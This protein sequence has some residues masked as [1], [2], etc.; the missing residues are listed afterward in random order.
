MV[1]RFSRRSA[2]LASTALLAVAA[3]PCAGAKELRITIPRSSKLTVVQRLNREGVEAARKHEPERAQAYFYKAYLYDPGDPF[4]LNNLGYAAEIQGDAE[5]AQKFYGLA[6]KQD[7]D[8]VID[9]SSLNQ[10]RGKP[11]LYALQD[12]QDAS[13]RLN[14]INVE[15]IELLIQD[16]GF[17]AARL[18]DRALALDPRNP[19]TLNNLGVAEEL[20]GDLEGAAMHYGAAAETH[21][22]EA[23]VVSPKRVWRGKAISEMASNSLE[24][25]QA[26]LEKEGPA[27]ARAVMLALRGVTAANGNDW[28]QAK[29]DF[30]EAYSLDPASAF[31]LNN[32]GYV[33]EKE[34]DLETAQFFYGKARRAG[35]AAARVGVATQTAAQ[36]RPMTVVADDS[37]TKVDT[38]LDRFRD[39]QRLQ[40]E[41]PELVPRGA[42]ASPTPPEPT[43]P[44]NPQP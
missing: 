33:A 9:L 38:E 41:P 32:R 26:E 23:I 28:T 17:E 43:A 13:M 24:R 12:L 27:K 44:A 7:C 5:R 8:A 37:H 3:W 35:D 29:Q 16:R 31:S 2:A 39:A 40:Q 10:L 1:L 22:T 25:M 11:M 18:L 30:L 42:G 15:A 14:R 4:T 21:S 6:E 20:T 36:G 34:G 19:F